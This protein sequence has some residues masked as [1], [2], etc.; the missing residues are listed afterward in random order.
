M[1]PLTYDQCLVLV[2]EAVCIWFFYLNH[3]YLEERSAHF[4]EWNKHQQKPAK[5]VKSD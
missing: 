1:I 2:L 5:E 4:S 3:H